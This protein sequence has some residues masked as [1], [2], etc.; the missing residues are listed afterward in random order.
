MGPLLMIG[1]RRRGLIDR[2]GVKIILI[3]RRLYCAKCERIHHELPDCI[4]PYK[5]HCAETIEEI[6][7]SGTKAEGPVKE[8]RSL[9]RIL[10]WW[11]VMLPYFL[12]VLTGLAEKHNTQFGDPPAFKT[13]IR[14]VVNSNRW[15]SAHSMSTRS[16]AVP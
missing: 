11:L 10:A 9:Q 12:G 4:V 7:S 6:I 15:N 1:T 5:R 2:D 14:A 13:I 8:S 16:A 3:I